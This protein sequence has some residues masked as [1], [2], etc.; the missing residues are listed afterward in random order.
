APARSRSSDGGA[1]SLYDR[2]ERCRRIARAADGGSLAKSNPGSRN[3]RFAC[4]HRSSEFRFDRKRDRRC[5]S[6]LACMTSG[7]EKFVQALRVVAPT[8]KRLLLEHLWKAFV[9]S[10]PGE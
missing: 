9:D 10:Q 1:A 4:G 7:A 5:A 3:W 6:C 8:K 2:C